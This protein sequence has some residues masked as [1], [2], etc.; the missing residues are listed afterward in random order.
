MPLFMHPG[1]L[2]G[3]CYHFLEIYIHNKGHLLV[4]ILKKQNMLIFLAITKAM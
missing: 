1:N 2:I 4:C 3:G